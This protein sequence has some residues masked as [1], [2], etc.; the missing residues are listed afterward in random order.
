MEKKGTKIRQ[1]EIV[2]KAI[3]IIG[4]FGASGL[5][6]ARLAESLGMSESNLYRHFNGKEAILSAVID[7]FG[8]LLMDKASMLA[9]E[10]MPPEEKLR[11][12]MASHVREV[13]QRS[14]M[15]RLVFSEDMHIRYPALRDKLAR[16]ISGYISTIESV[17]N[18][19][20]KD[21]SFKPDI[22]PG[23]TARA[24]LGMMQFAAMRWSLAGFSFSLKEEG[25]RLWVNFYRMIRNQGQL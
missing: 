24:Y 19:G 17:V 13:E 23:E 1:A 6:T 16:R 4:E 22:S 9:G 10:M 15:P 14:G 25:R 18:E 21:G 3:A 20:I 12:I 7:E 5:T 11:L 8:E 2:N